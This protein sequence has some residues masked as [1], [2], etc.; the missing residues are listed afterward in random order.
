MEKLNFQHEYGSLHC[1]MILKISF[2][3][4]GLVLKIF[5]LLLYR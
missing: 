4:A 2:V 3:Y 5:F 1:Q